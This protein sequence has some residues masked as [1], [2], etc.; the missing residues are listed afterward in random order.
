MS[1]ISLF[2]KYRSDNFEDLVGQEHIVRTISNAIKS[3]KI[4][5]G[6][7]FCG[8]RGT[9]KTTVA[10]IIAKAL[11]CIHG[12]TPIPCG[13]CEACISIKN[14]TA[15]DVYEMDAASNRGVDDIEAIV[16]SVRYRPSSFR[17]K[18]YIIDEAH[19]LSNQAKDAFLKTLEEPPPYIVFIL[20][21]TE[22][23]K[24]PVTIRSRCQQF[25]F[26]RGNLENISGRVA[27]VAEKEGVTISQEGITLIAR[28][29]NGSYRDSLSILEQIISFTGKEISYKD[30]TSVLGLI[31]EDLLFEISEA[32]HTEN[33]AEAFK[34]SNELI[35][36]GKDI[37]DA[38]SSVA[39][40]YRDLL[41]IKIGSD[42]N[43]SIRWIEETEKYSEQELI[44]IMEVFLNSEKNIRFT[45]DV[46]LVFEMA[47]MKA[48]IKEKK[49][50]I[51]STN[52]LNETTTI[53]AQESNSALNNTEKQGNN[54]LKIEKKEPIKVIQA[55]NIEPI[56]EKERIDNSKSNIVIEEQKALIDINNI[57]QNWRKIIE[58]LRIGHKKAQLS[59][60]AIVGHP[61]EYN[62]GLLTV[63]FRYDN[64]YH[65]QVC[66]NEKKILET[67]F[68]E[69][70]KIPIKMEF[71][72]HNPPEINITND[73]EKNINE[74]E[75][76]SPPDFSDA[77]KIESNNYLND[78]I[79][80][81]SDDNSSI[82]QY[83]S[84]T[85]IKID[86][87]LLEKELPSKTDK[88]ILED[89]VKE[90]TSAETSIS[91]ITIQEDLKKEAFTKKQN[92]I[93][94]NN[95]NDFHKDSSFENTSINQ[96]EKINPLNNPK[97]DDH[98]LYKEAIRVFP[99]AEV[100]I[101]DK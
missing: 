68:K 34:H 2:R 67:V 79:A 4:P 71:I 78:N 53:I 77:V 98:P 65:K 57:K 45:G 83:E 7:L 51:Y 60:C 21:T 16:D 3:N 90:E 85:E 92:D 95:N 41:A 33:I 101:I 74:F 8:T 62:N 31:E 15:V 76:A 30:V 18:V 12:P 96:E 63:T 89:P 49:S 13:I 50:Q 99:N 40:F 84:K 39:G 56:N 38:M 37:K 69:C 10:R 87:M 94:E 75:K 20:A 54:T 88:S 32:I 47:F 14:G 17:Y 22:A 27:L 81:M 48:C 26:R 24:I 46:R 35:N 93:F 82:S 5:Q 97:Y 28:A 11:N 66:E 70:Y 55:Q 19:Q 72:L 29:A 52:Y 80:E 43:R 73:E 59:A 61:T 64:E 6:Y 86:P 25:D 36:N 58:Y 23:H 42:K 44:R 1:Y 9:G 100:E 91:K